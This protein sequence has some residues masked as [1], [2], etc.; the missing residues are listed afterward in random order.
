MIRIIVALAILLPLPCLADSREYQ[1]LKE[2]NR[3]MREEYKRRVRA[4]IEENERA[5]KRNERDWMS[6]R[7]DPFEYWEREKE[8]EDKDWEDRNSL[9]D[10]Q[11]FE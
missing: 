3:L 4:D 8:I 9:N 6:G 2:Q 5:D 1:A 7:I 11:G 10:F